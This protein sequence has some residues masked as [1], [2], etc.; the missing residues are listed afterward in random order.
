MKNNTTIEK[1]AFERGYK[2]GFEEGRRLAYVKL[3]ALELDVKLGAADEKFMHR[4]EA[5]PDADALWGLYQLLKQTDTGE[6]VRQLLD[7]C[8]KE[9]ASSQVHG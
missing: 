6:Q 7:L 2:N 4:V 8:R 1:L 3:I 9:R 5:L